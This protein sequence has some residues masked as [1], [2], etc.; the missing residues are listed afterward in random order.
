MDKIKEIFSKV[1]DSYELQVN[2]EKTLIL[3]FEQYTKDNNL[4]KLWK[5]I[6]KISTEKDSDIARAKEIKKDYV[7]Y[8]AFF[9]QIVYKLSQIH[10]LK[11]KRIFLANFS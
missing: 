9:T 11:Y 10:E 2:Y 4:E 5:K 1:L 6:I 7:D 3:D 8:P